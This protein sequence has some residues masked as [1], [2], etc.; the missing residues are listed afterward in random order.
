MGL[1][2]VQVGCGCSIFGWGTVAGPVTAPLHVW[3]TSHLQG[4]FNRTIRMLESGVKPVYV[5]DGKP[6]T[7]KS[8]EV[9]RAF[10]AEFGQFGF[11]PE[12]ARP[13]PHPGPPPCCRPHLFS[14]QSARQPRKR[15]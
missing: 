12:R 2:R 14:W 6:P 10:V 9:R 15:Q 4:M 5:F 8:G 1:S 13:I 3:I 11:F 7:M